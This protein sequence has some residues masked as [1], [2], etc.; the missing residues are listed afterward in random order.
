MIFDSST[1]FS[2]SRSIRILFQSVALPFSSIGF[3]FAAFAA[4]FF[5][6]AASFC[7][8]LRTSR[9]N[10]VFFTL[11]KVSSDPLERK[12]ENTYGVSLSSSLRASFSPPKIRCTAL[13]WCSSES[14]GKDML[15]NVKLVRQISKVRKLNPCLRRPSRFDS[16]A[17]KGSFL[18]LWGSGRLR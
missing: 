18:A 2:T 12:E 13:R 17:A 11:Q 7:S 9:C 15:N 14:C 5:F 10:L 8:A 6:F 16:A 3:L 4:F 1:S